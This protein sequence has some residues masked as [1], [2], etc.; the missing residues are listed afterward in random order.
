MQDSIQFHW[1][2]GFSREY[3]LQGLKGSGNLMSIDSLSILISLYLFASLR[4]I[5]NIEGFQLSSKSYHQ[6]KHKELEETQK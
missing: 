4:L 5:A 3:F 1:W 6:Y 2:Y